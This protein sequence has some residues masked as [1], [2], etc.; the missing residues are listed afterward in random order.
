MNQKNIRNFC[1]I[2]H[3][4]H[5]KSTLADRLLE[6]TNTIEKRK[7]REQYLD[8]HPLER[9]RGITIKMQPVQMSYV[10]NSQPYI[11]NL[12]DTPGHIDFNYEVSRALAAVEGAILLVDATKGIQ[13]QTLANLELAREQNLKVLAAINKIDKAE[14]Y[15]IENVRNELRSL[16]FNAEEI[17]SVSAKTG[18][19]VESLLK[20]IVESLPAPTADIIGN[21]RALVFDYEY[22]HHRGLIAHIR[23]T[24]GQIQAGDLLILANA[25]E[26]FTVQ[27][28]GIFKPELSPVSKLN[29]GEIGYL[30]TGIK[31]L[32]NFRVGETVVSEK[33]IRDVFFG[34]KN[35]SPVI[36]SNIYPV[37]PENFE[38]LRDSLKKLW[39]EDNSFSFAPEKNS[40]LGRGF[41]LGF[42]GTLHLEIILE[43]LR[44]DFNQMI[45]LT[46]PSVAFEIFDKNGNPFIIRS[47][48]MFPE[49]RGFSDVKEPILS[50]EIIFPSVYLKQII[51]LL[52]GFK[53][54]ASEVNNFGQEKLK[55]KTEMALREF[56]KKFYDQLKSASKGMASL[57]YRMIG[58]KKSDLCR[59]D[60]EI[61]GEK[62]F[63][64]SMVILRNE[65]EKEA[66][67]VVGRLA[68]IL[69]RA[70]FDQKIQAIV[71]GRILASR[72]VPAL[73]KDVTGYLYGGDRT[74][75]MKLWQKQSRG[76]R[77]LVQ[78]AKINIHP[79]VFLEMLK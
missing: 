34:Y 50:L 64:F 76:K 79:R 57:S 4:D 11:L 35:P 25:K 74:R 28:T 47:A 33:N 68:E 8:M 45:I 18:E 46:E 31:E 70:L 48:D 20:A 49:E 30:I 12:I 37:Q 69:P 15:Q 2:A 43:R 55:L 58:F 27:E 17:L 75:K 3:I 61:N 7:M 67:L 19:G 10:L 32:K 40:F 16:N 9:E 21:P 72:K 41:Q 65:A 42:L 1:V 29:A 78:R 56:T 38:S 22:S 63:P 44:R 52:R 39:L 53:A 5:G 62:I 26:K 59:L 54:E 51:Q 14:P 6:I 23:L 71:L 13:A 36:F 24:N 60:V 73:K 77:R 66:R